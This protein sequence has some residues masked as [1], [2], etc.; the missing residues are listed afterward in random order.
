MPATGTA[1]GCLL[2]H[3]RMLA[4]ADHLSQAGR[5][6]WESFRSAFDHEAFLTP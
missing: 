5:L 1:V 4:N 2:V 6:P 3:T